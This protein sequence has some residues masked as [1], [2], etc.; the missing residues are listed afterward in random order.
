[1]AA[2]LQGRWSR[3]L[4]PPPRRSL[5]GWSPHRP[6]GPKRRAWPYPFQ[7][8]WRRSPRAAGPWSSRSRFCPWAL[9]QPWRFPRPRTQGRQPFARC[10]RRHRRRPQT[11][12]RQSAWRSV[13]PPQSWRRCNWRPRW[14][15]RRPYLTRWSCSC[16]LSSRRRQARF[17][18]CRS[19]S[20][21]RQAFRTAWSSRR[22]EGRRR[23]AQA[24]ARRRR[25]L[26]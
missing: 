13:C 16:P 15:S 4:F 22:R 17:R 23:S 6:S 9:P 19:L 26:R 21:W 5:R 20:V 7:S 18:F 2:P 11:A 8:C 12:P 14:N 3:T 25:L 1:L 10:C 24:L